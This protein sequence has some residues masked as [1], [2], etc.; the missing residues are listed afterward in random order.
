[1]ATRK[2]TDVLVFLVFCLTLF[3]ATAI[4]LRFSFLREEE[5]TRIRVTNSSYLISEWIRGSFITSDYVLRDIVTEIPYREFPLLQS[6]GPEYQRLSRFLENKRKTLPYAFTASLYN[7]DC[8]GVISNSIPKFDAG[9]REYCA[10]LKGNPAI[11][12]VVTNVF[13]SSLGRLNVVQARR[14]EASD[15]EFHGFAL[16]GMDLDF[17]SRWLEAV[18]VDRGSVIA[19]FDRNRAV[20]ARRPTVPGIVGKILAN[21]PLAAFV[22]SDLQTQTFRGRSDIDGVDRLYAVRKVDP[23]P[24]VISVGEADHQ[25]QGRWRSRAAGEAGATLLLILMAIVILRNHRAL[26]R[27]SSDLEAANRLLANLSVTDGLTGVANR[28][29]FDDALSREFSRAARSR[30]PLSLIMIDVDHFKRYNDH[31]GHQAGD[32]CLR[33]VAALLQRSAQRVTDVAA[34]YGGEEF[35]VILPGTDTPA[36]AR[37]AEG[38][39]RAVE[40]GSIP[41][42][43]SPFATVTISIGIASLSSAGVV[44]PDS[45]IG[46]ADQA[47]YRAKQAGRNQIQIAPPASPAGDDPGDDKPGAAKPEDAPT[48]SQIRLSWQPAYDTGHARIDGQHRALFQA[49]ATLLTAMLSGRPNT[50]L[51]PLFDAVIAEFERHFEDEEAILSEIGFPDI[52]A[53]ASLH[54]QLE[55]DAAHLAG[56]LRE[57]RSGLGGI[58]QFLAQDMIRRHMLEAD[59]SYVPYLAGATAPPSATGALPTGRNPR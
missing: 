11:E 28:R 53:H 10:L 6:E 29:H 14:F 26:I 25:W 35:A 17:F 9:D 45:L 49:T 20:L 57:G 2:R 54:R 22:A 32:D 1:M 15:G 4:D 23:F 27:R 55:S 33:K 34:R 16:L 42:A 30:T 50:D 43:A 7:Q 44:G 47:L 56:Q 8:V 41:H 37:L 12:S 46:A 58:F 21:K 40:R 5:N 52:D 36:A 39:R 51:A 31:Y 3:A 19:I 48:T 18:A 59:R 24:F 13:R 38:I